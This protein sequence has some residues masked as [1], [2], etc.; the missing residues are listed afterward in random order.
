MKKSK[1][2]LLNLLINL[3]KQGNSVAGYAAT[4]KVYYIKFMWNKFRFDR[5]Y[6]RYTLDKQNKF[7]P[8]MH[9]PIKSNEYFK[10]KFVLFCK[11]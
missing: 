1:N 9:I 2:D 6:C 5:L 10:K 7:S 8:G 11:S 3:K 4:L